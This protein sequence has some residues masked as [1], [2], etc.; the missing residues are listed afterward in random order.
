MSR[1]ALESS[2]SP[3]FRPTRAKP[4]P[5]FSGG[6]PQCP[7]Y[8]EGAARDEWRRVVHLLAE[9]G[10]LTRADGP[11]LELYC[12]TY[13]AWRQCVEEIAKDGPI[14]EVVVLDARGEPH[15]VRKQSEASKLATKLSASLRQLLKELG[16]TPASREK[17]TP[18]KD[19]YRKK[20]PEPVVPGTVGWMLQQRETEN[21]NQSS[22]SEPESVG[23]EFRE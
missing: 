20:E 10:T 3:H 19:G 17:A 18:A 2:P 8:L 22:S 23:S 6:R 16:S 4:K 14:C 15:T 11:A 9:R 7:S 21:G 1:P 5:Q 12:Q 13:S